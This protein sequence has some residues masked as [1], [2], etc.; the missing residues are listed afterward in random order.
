MTSSGHSVYGMS[1]VQED[2]LHKSKLTIPIKSE[3][4]LLAG[5][6]MFGWVI[7]I[8]I[9]NALHVVTSLLIMVILNFGLA[10]VSV[11]M[12]QTSLSLVLGWIRRNGLSIDRNGVKHI[13]HSLVGWHQIKGLGTRKYYGPKG[14]VEDIF[15]LCLH[16]HTYEAIKPSFLAR[17]MAFYFYT[18]EDLTHS[19]AIRVQLIDVDAMALVQKS[20][21]IASEADYPD[22]ARWCWLESS[23]WTQNQ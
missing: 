15:L 3:H 19:I 23:G 17:F 2:Q 10:V 8:F 20:R 21:D 11:W 7:I 16:P 13:R 1:S 18:Y 9:F 22:I 12:I 4:V 6:L 5:A 14:R